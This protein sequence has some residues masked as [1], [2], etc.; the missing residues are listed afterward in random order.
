MSRGNIDKRIEEEAEKLAQQKA[1]LAQLR[2]RK[3]KIDRK[4]ETR[5]KILAGAVVLK[6][7]YGNAEF[8]KQLMEWLDRGLVEERDRSL[9]DFANGETNPVSNDNGEKETKDQNISISR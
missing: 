6:K 3:A 4:N 7:A 9:F 8:K 2:A 5:R 1:V